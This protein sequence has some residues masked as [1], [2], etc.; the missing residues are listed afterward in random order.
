MYATITDLAAAGIDPG[1]PQA[2]ARRLEAADTAVRL[3]LRGAVYD[4]GDPAFLDTAR[5]ATVAQA[6]ALT[7]AGLD[8]ANP[9]TSGERVVASKS[10][11]AASLSYADTRNPVRAMTSLAS[12]T[13]CPWAEN[14][15]TAAGLT[16]RVEAIG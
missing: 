2:A 15:L 11:G 12:G 14:I 10:L 9:A 4:P 6:S 5:R 3:R 7:T 16:P 13:L 8:P 1:D